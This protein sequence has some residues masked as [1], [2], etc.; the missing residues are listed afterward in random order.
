MKS[1]KFK[2][3]KEEYKKAYPTEFSTFNDKYLYE[4]YLLGK[5]PNK[6]DVNYSSQPPNKVSNAIEE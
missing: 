5:K 3:W 6:D 4:I 1:K 2:N